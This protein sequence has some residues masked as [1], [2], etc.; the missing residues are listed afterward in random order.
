M[1]GTASC[2]DSAAHRYLIPLQLV[3]L[4]VDNSRP[5]S[6]PSALCD[7]KQSDRPQVNL[8]NILW[9]TRDLYKLGYRLKA[10]QTAP[11]DGKAALP[12]Q[13]PR[14]QTDT[15]VKSFGMPSRLKSSTN[16]AD[17]FVPTLKRVCFQRCR[18]VWRMDSQTF[19]LH[20]KEAQAIRSTVASHSLALRN[21]GQT[22]ISCVSGQGD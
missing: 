13:T 6:S 4:H 1:H 21:V 11:T 12:N 16:E 9:R 22:Y 15:S 3:A 14:S 17:R 2:R 20:Q 10:L 5:L 18:W 7:P 8:L 19:R